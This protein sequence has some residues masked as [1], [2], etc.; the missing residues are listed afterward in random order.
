MVI[1]GF[2]PVVS[3]FSLELKWS[4]WYCPRSHRTR[5][6]VLKSPILTWNKSLRQWQLQNK[7]VVLKIGT[8]K[9]FITWWNKNLAAQWN[10]LYP[11][12]QQENPSSEML[13]TIANQTYDDPYISRYGGKCGWGDKVAQLYQ[14]VLNIKLRGVF[15]RCVRKVIKWINL[16]RHVST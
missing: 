7:M 5:A 12:Q 2:Q 1:F 13:L 9:N 3:L 4:L 6:Y 14:T 11:W 8:F 10:S 15:E 16:E